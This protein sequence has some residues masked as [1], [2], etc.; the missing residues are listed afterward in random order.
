MPGGQHTTVRCTASA[1]TVLPAGGSENHG[2]LGLRKSPDPPV[3]RVLWQESAQ[4]AITLLA[5]LR[6]GMQVSTRS[7]S[8]CRCFYLRNC[9]QSLPP[10]CV[11]KQSLGTRGISGEME[12]TALG[13]RIWNERHCKQGGKISLGSAE[14]SVTLSP[15]SRSP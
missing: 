10:K 2:L 6:L 7:C 11:P 14:I 9:R 12:Y 3:A 8:L 15:D 4:E 5:K 13:G 1:S